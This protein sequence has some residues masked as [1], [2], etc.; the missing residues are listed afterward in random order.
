MTNITNPKAKK[1]IVRVNKTFKATSASVESNPIPK[2]VATEVTGGGGE[3]ISL[4]PWQCLVSGPRQAAYLRE[5]I[6]RFI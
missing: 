2:N 3:V 5:Q 6:N 4:C 1:T